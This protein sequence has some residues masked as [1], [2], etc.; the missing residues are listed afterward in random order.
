MTVEPLAWRLNGTEYE[1][2]RLGRTFVRPGLGPELIAEKIR[3]PS[4]LQKP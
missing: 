4:S 1:R 2:T 3:G